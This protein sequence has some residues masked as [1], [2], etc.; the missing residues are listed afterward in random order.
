MAPLLPDDRQCNVTRVHNVTEMTAGKT[1]RK[2]GNTR[3][4]DDLH[5]VWDRA[6]GSKSISCYSKQ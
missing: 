5:P 2:Q 4:M 1:L 6:G 3:Q